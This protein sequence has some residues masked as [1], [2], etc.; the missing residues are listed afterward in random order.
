MKNRSKQLLVLLAVQLVVIALLA[1]TNGGGSRLNFD[2]QLFTVADT[3]SITA[4]ELVLNENETVKLSAVGGRWLINEAEVADPALMIYVKSVLTRVAVQRPI[5]TRQQEQV[6][7]DLET[8]APRVKIF[9]GEEV[10]S[11]FYAGGNEGKTKSYFAKEGTAY[12]VN[13]PGYQDYLSG[14]FKLRAHQWKDRRVSSSSWRSISKI[15]VNKR[16]GD[17]FVVAFTGRDL[18]VEGVTPLDTNN[19]MNYVSQYAQ[20]V[21]NEFVVPGQ[22]ARYDSLAKT[23][24]EATITLEDIDVNRNFTWNIYPRLPQEGYHLITDKEG[25]MMMVDM[26]RVA[27]LIPPRKFFIKRKPPENEF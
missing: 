1:F 19:M 24:P 16:K 26:R 15:A 8:N 2:T 20:F 22:F 18:T 17:G 14:I 11:D 10:I 21:I 7:S 27:N 5:S 25:R 13:V 4:I 12:I 23:R 6:R 3:A 9:A